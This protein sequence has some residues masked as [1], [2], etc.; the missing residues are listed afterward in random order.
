[1]QTGSAD[2]PCTVYRT[3]HVGNDE[4]KGKLAKFEDSSKD[5]YFRTG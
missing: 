1:M 3:G 2:R 5:I 4:G